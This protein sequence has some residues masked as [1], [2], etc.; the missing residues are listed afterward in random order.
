MGVSVALTRRADAAGLIALQ[1][2]YAEPGIR[3]SELADRLRQATGLANSTVLALLRRLEREGHL[4]GE[5][6]GKQKSYRPV[7]NGAVT[8][9]TG[10]H[11]AA[12]ATGVL[13]ASAG[14]AFFL[15]PDRHESVGSGGE[16]AAAPKAAPKAEP[17][18]K[19]AP[20][21]KPAPKAKAKAKPKPKP[22]PASHALARAK[23]IT[24]ASLSGS[25]VPGIAGKT[26]T[27]LKRKGFKV[28]TV[29]NAPGPSAHSFVYYARGAKE[30]ARAVARQL[31]I[32]NVRHVGSNT[33]AAAQGAKLIVVIGGGKP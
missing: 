17:A 11:L 32:R 14:I 27:K 23:H 5:R 3:Q 31:G 2:V 26:A 16:R 19:A 21:A 8:K 12:L 28:G 1:E 4:E 7:Q 6:E 29:A 25:Y 30:P 13:L 18:P 15:A 10:R 9:G 22:K 24:I 33:R 20:K